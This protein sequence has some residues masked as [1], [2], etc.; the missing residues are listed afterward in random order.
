[1]RQIVRTALRALLLVGLLLVGL[2][3]VGVLASVGSAQEPITLDDVEAG[4]P[5]I[6]ADEPIAV[7]YSAKRAA[8]YLD[9]SALNWQKTKKC[10]T[11]HM[12]MAYTQ[13]KN[14]GEEQLMLG[15]GFLSP[16]NDMHAAA[17]DG[18]S[19]SLCNQIQDEDLGRVDECAG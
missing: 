10:A 2:L 15:K 13:A 18:V 5:E 4:L 3:L 17:M 8:Q 9:R 6:T 1:M 19:C 16:K 11:C 7:N 14:K 12:P